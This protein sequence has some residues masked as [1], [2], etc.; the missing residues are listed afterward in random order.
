MFGL[1]MSQKILQI[2]MDQI[3]NRAPGII[4]LQTDIFVFGI[5][6]N[7]IMTTL[8]NFCR[9]P[10]VMLFTFKEDDTTGSF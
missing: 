4:T 7:N 1:R 8:S 2:W 6:L 10:S 9:Q 3:T 5:H